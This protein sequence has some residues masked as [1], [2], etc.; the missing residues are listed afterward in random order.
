VSC[1]RSPRTITCDAGEDFVSGLGPDEGLGRV[2]GNS[3]IVSNGGLQFAHAAMGTAPD[4]FVGRGSKEPFHEVDPR[5]AGGREVEMEAWPFGEPAPDQHRLVRAIV[6]QNEMHETCRHR[7]V[8]AIEELAELHTA[9]PAVQFT[10]HC[11]GFEIERGKQQ[12]R[13]M[14][15]VVMGPAFHLAGVGHEYGGSRLV[16]RMLPWVWDCA[17]HRLKRSSCQPLSAPN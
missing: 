13:A 11:T 12:C 14:A 6:V 10:D 2:V 7:V 5:G 4:L 9:M 3:E 1:P 17:K 15:L 16:I 8:N